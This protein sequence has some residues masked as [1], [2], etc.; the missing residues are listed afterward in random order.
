MKFDDH[1]LQGRV[2]ESYAEF[3]CKIKKL[4]CV[5]QGGEME[6]QDL[7]EGQQDNPLEEE[8]VEDET[9]EEGVRDGFCLAISIQFNSIQYIIII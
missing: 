8:E 2:R 9:E 7:E 6:G 1:F 5:R 4:V 3:V